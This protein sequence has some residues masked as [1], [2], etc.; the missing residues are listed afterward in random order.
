MKIPRHR[1]FVF[2]PLALVTIAAIFIAGCGGGDGTT[3]TTENETA[4]AGGGAGGGTLAI[5]LG[6]FFFA[7]KNVTAKAG[8]TTIE[9]PN[10]GSVEHELVLFKTNM[11]PAKL[12]TEAAGGVDEEK[13]DQVAEEGGEVADV[14]AGKTKSGKFHLTPGKYVM[15]CNLPGHYAQGMYG[16]LTVTK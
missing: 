5:K 11:N 4:A 14:E 8:P 6:D 7:P 2:A 3:T 16:T 15:F 13:M 12:P 1:L 10:E 9:A